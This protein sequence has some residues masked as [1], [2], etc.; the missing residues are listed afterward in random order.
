MKLFCLDL[1]ATQI[2]ELSQMPRKRA[3][4]ALFKVKGVHHTDD[5]WRGYDGL[6]DLG[7]AKTRIG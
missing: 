7:F 2:A 3:F 6:V 5:G 1:T 4:N